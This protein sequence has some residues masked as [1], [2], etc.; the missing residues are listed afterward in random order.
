MEEIYKQRFEI[1]TSDDKKAVNQFLNLIK[2]EILSQDNFIYNNE[3]WLVCYR[4]F[5]HSPD[6]IVDERDIKDNEKFLLVRTGSDRTVIYGYC[7]KKQLMSVPA[8]DIYRNSTQ[9]Y[10]VMDTN[11]KDLTCFKIIKEGFVLK[12]QF[13]INQQ[14]ADNLGQTEMIS[15]ILAGFHYFAKKAGLYF[16]DLNQRDEFVTEDKK[17]RIFV[18]D[19]LS[20]SDMLVPNQYF[21]SHPEID[22]F[23][24]C[25]IKGGKYD[26]QGYTTRE[27]LKETRIVSMTGNSDMDQTGEKIRRIFAEQ[28]KPISD[29]IKIYEEEKKEEIII[30]PQSY[31]P[32]HQHSE[33]SILDGF[34]TCKYIAEALKKQGFKAA[35][36]TDHGSLAGVW[37]FQKECLL[38]DV[39]PIIGCEFYMNLKDTDGRFHITILVKNKTGWQNILKLQ[40]ISAREHFYY[41][42][43]INFD[44]LLQYH[45]GL[46]VLSGCSSGLISRFIENEKQE[47][48]EE[49]ILQLKE[50]FKDDFYIEIMPHNIGKN[51]EVMEKLYNLSLK[52]KL[53][54]VITTDSHYPYKEDKKFH[55]AVKAIGQKK[56]YG[57]AGFSDNCFYLM[58]DK[59]L[60]ERIN[61]KCLWMKDL[62]KGFMKNT[63]E[64]ADK[65]DFKIEKG[66]ERDT[67]PRFC[68]INNKERFFEVNIKEKFEI[69]KEKVKNGEEKLLLTI[70]NPVID[71]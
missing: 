58:Q 64:I 47:R 15:G 32:L 31:V 66:E 17:A 18:R 34:G 46:I 52:Y 63:F 65:C 71:E 12:Q 61:E 51:Q 28:Y 19:F 4:P 22:I 44:E 36:L 23:I 11:V 16:R 45:E 38:Q 53:K 29:L 10:V 27:V 56:K 42:P 54:C 9:C 35:A 69:W 41:K 60:Q 7:D 50:V 43:I 67:L 25:K 57:E 70:A 59:D 1:E 33:F 6:I 8:R 40:A 3:K 5:T 24:L 30:I 48:A 39:K 37:T 13:I 14:E 68:E 62:Y 20:D 2:A 49:L 26:Y 21:L 55:E